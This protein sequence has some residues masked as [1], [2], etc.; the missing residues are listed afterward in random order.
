MKAFTK[1]I[2]SIKSKGSSSN[3]PVSVDINDGNLTGPEL[4]GQ[5]VVLSQDI[6]LENVLDVATKESILKKGITYA[7][8][9]AFNSQE[10]QSGL[11]SFAKAVVVG[12][13]PSGLGNASLLDQLVGGSNNGGYQSPEISFDIP[14]QDDL[15]QTDTVSVSSIALSDPDSRNKYAILQSQ[16]LN[17]LRS[18]IIAVMEYIPIAKPSSYFGS[19]DNNSEYEE[20]GIKKV[21]KIIELHRQ[22]REYLLMA[23][24][25]VF[26]NTYGYYALIDDPVKFLQSNQSQL[27]ISNID[28]ISIGNA[29]NSLG[30]NQAL[31]SLMYESIKNKLILLFGNL[32][33]TSGTYGNTINNLYNSALFENA[34]SSNTNDTIVDVVYDSIKNSNSFYNIFASLK[35]VEFIKSL[36]EFFIYRY[37]I[38]IIIES[39]TSLNVLSKKITD[40]WKIDISGNT[41][42][43]NLNEYFGEATG[44][45]LNSLLVSSEVPD[46]YEN[47]L[48]I[49]KSQGCSDTD[50]L[51]QTLISLYGQMSLK[52]SAAALNSADQLSLAEKQFNGDVFKTSIKGDLNEDFRFLRKFTIL[53]LISGVGSTTD[54]RA[55]KLG[56]SYRDD[57]EMSPI[58]WA[59]IGNETDKGLQ[60]LISPTEML[61]AYAFDFCVNLNSARRIGFNSNN[62]NFPFSSFGSLTHEDYRRKVLLGEFNDISFFDSSEEKTID[63]QEFYSKQTKEPLILGGTYISTFNN[64]GVEIFE[65]EKTFNSPSNVSGAEYVYENVSLAGS[66]ESSLGKDGLTDQNIKNNIDTVFNHY[67]GASKSFF[68]DLSSIFINYYDANNSNGNIAKKHPIGKM[69]PKH[70]IK[71]LLNYLADDIDTIIAN[72]NKFIPLLATFLSQENTRLGDKDNQF[73][74]FLAMFWGYLDS[75]DY[76]K[77]LNLSAENTDNSKRKIMSDLIG[78]LNHYYNEQITENFFKNKLECSTLYGTD[79]IGYYGGKYAWSN[80]KPPAV[81]G[82]R[83][84]SYLSYNEQFN[85]DF[86]GFNGA[87][88][89][90]P[91]TLGEPFFES[92]NLP[93]EVIFEGQHDESSQVT[94][95][96]KYRQSMI[97]SG[98]YSDVESSFY[99]KDLS[100]TNSIEPAGIFK[101]FRKSFGAICSDLDF[102]NF[103]GEEFN[104][105]DNGVITNLEEV[106][107]M[108]D[109]DTENEGLDWAGVPIW[110]NDGPGYKSSL[111]PLKLKMHHKAIL[112]Y[113]WLLTL[114][115]KPYPGSVKLKAIFEDFDYQNN[116]SS[117]SI[118]YNKDQLKGL[119][120]GLRGAAQRIGSIENLKEYSNNIISSGVDMYKLTKRATIEKI[121]PLVNTIDDRYEKIATT[122]SILINHS[123]EIRKAYQGQNNLSISPITFLALSPLLETTSVAGVVNDQNVIKKW[124]S[125]GQTI[126]NKYSMTSMIKSMNR[127]FA[128]PNDHKFLVNNSLT[129]NVNKIKLMYKILSQSGY[130]FLDEE[131]KGLKSII[132]VGIPAGM[133]E[134]LQKNAFQET[135]NVDYLDSNYICIIVNKN[136]HISE[137]SFLYPKIFVFDAGANILDFDYLSLRTGHVDADHL[138]NYSDEE[139]LATTLS[140][141]KITRFADFTFGSSS[142]LIGTFSSVAAKNDN[143]TNFNSEDGKSILMNH[144]IDYALKLYMYL[145]TGIIM[146]E[147]TFSFSLGQVDTGSLNSEN[148]D[149]KKERLFQHILNTL[150]TA[151]PQVNE[152]EQLRNEVFRLTNII[153]QMPPFSNKINYMKTMLPRKFDKVYSVFVN[154]KDFTLAGDPQIFDSPT[155]RNIGSQIEVASNNVNN[156]KLEEAVAAYNAVEG[157][158]AS[159]SESSLNE[160]GEYAENEI[161][162]GFNSQEEVETFTETLQDMLAD[163]FINR[164]D[165]LN[166]QVTSYVNSLNKNAPE[167]YNYSVNIALLPASKFK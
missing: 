66:L 123:H 130:G 143:Q 112:W 2:V 56:E 126:V 131:E 46:L 145:T 121:I 85:T 28:A 53:G 33:N 150:S 141:I 69:S 118:R 1:S 8:A 101:L 51:Y 35:D 58:N 3:A 22:I 83:F 44:L 135:G 17:V 15:S 29:F 30:P 26:A 122:A 4:G 23:A 153:K 62:E 132:N 64:A 129:T 31:F 133:I 125:A 124:T 38:E 144:A 79:D 50:L 73:K 16:G 102:D 9:P 156:E 165:E 114:L 63:S 92:F 61:A 32:Q 48:G 45:G 70:R 78:S 160:L 159:L 6:N 116:K 5:T 27:G 155:N 139:S 96:T 127:Y 107:K 113:K 55:L 20:G 34:S 36:I 146:D 18:E 100:N 162:D 47:Y 152:D 59:Y 110:S 128:M 84:K 161:Q 151:Y 164:S 76:R 140:N 117:F 95:M 86:Q 106:V 134:T 93:D 65:S 14:E 82:N 80:F 57:I 77:V 167:V 49:L 13:A 11:S 98:L 75:P 94:W 142:D 37:F 87:A 81:A 68:N 158:Q 97:G 166:K 39:Y 103:L 136:D 42:I 111:G 120:D 72:P 24:S 10:S 67:A 52:D 74:T 25:K 60:N 163:I 41:A 19:A 89:H 54:N 90:F 138:I 109:L 43:D 149:A 105:P 40:A 99:N 115:V 108:F 88:I 148:L 104:Y 154:E 119:R 147:E 71:N 91:N 137:N 21:S 12:Q 157:L 7:V